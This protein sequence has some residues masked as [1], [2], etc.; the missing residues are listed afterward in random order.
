MTNPFNKTIIINKT[1]LRWCLRL[2]LFGIVAFTPS[3]AFAQSAIAPDNTLGAESSNVVTNVN[4]LPVEV[5]TGGATRGINLF[6]SFREFNVNEGRGAYFFSNSSNIQNIL[7]RVTGGNRSEIFGRLGTS[8]ESKANL[9]LINP[10]GIV[11]GQNASLDV[12]GS[13]MATTANGIQFGNQGSFNATNPQAPALL[14]VNPSALLFNQINTGVGITNQSQ[15]PTG[16]NPIGVNVTGLRVPDGKSLLL[17][18]GNINLDGGRLVA[19]EG[20]VELAG[21]ASP[22]SVGLNVI[23]NALSLNVPNDLQLADVSLSN[24]AFISAFGAGGGDITINARNIEMSNSQLYAGIGRNLGDVT[25]QAGDIKLNATGAISLKDSFLENSVYGRGNAGNIFI[26]APNTFS[27]TSSSVFSNVEAGGSGKAG[28]ININSGS[29]SI[30]DGAAIQTLLREGNDKYSPARGEGGNINID[31]GGAVNLFGEK[32]GFGSSIASTV[33]TNVEGNGGNI[34]IKSGSLS[35]ADGTSVNASTSGQGNAGNISVKARDAISL[36]GGDIFSIVGAGAVGNAGN[37]DIIGNSLS[38]TQN[39]QIATEVSQGNGNLP[40]GRGNGGNINIDV[41]GAVFIGNKKPGLTVNGISTLVRP[42]AEGNSGSITMNAGSLEV[43]NGSELQASN[44]G[45]GNTGNITINARDTVRFDGGDT[46]SNLVSRAINTVFEGNAGNINITTGSLSLSNLAF[47][48]SSTNGKGNAGNIT[49]NTRDVVNLDSLGY[50]SSDASFGSVGNGGEIKLTTGVL[51]LLNG[52]TISSSVYG[53]GNGGNIIIDARDSVLVDGINNK[54]V[55]NGTVYE[56]TSGLI[57]TL[58]TREVG[59]G[60]NIQITTGSL[61]VKNNGQLN[62]NTNGR[63]NAGNI[64]INARDTV[65]FDGL[66]KSPSIASSGA[67]DFFG[68]GE[69]L[70]SGGNI[71][72]NARALFLKNGG[73]ISANG[74]TGNAGNITIDVSDIVSIDGVD[75]SELGLLSSGITSQVKG[76]SIRLEESNTLVNGGDIRINTKELFLSNGGIIAADSVGFANAGNITINARDT[77]NFDGVGTNGASSG[78]T[79]QLLGGKG[80]GGDI[81]L[82]TGF[83]TLSN[84]AAINSNSN[85]QGNA[86]SIFINARDAIT[87]KDVGNNGATSFISSVIFTSGVGKGGDIQI[88]SRTLSLSDSAFLGSNTFGQGNA[89]NIEINLAGNMSVNKAALLSSTLGEGDAGNIAINLTGDLNLQNSSQINTATY[90]QGSAGDIFVDAKN[91]IFLANNSLITSNVGTGSV[92]KGGDIDVNTK[93]LTL[94][95]GSQLATAVFRQFGDIPGG[96]GKAGDIRINASDSVTLSGIGLLGNSTGLV[97]LTERGAFGDAGNI[98]V[99][100][101]KFQLADGANAIASTFNDSKG[102][103]IMIN[104]NTFAAVNGGQVITNTRGSGNAGNIR[105]NVKDNITI[106]GSDPNFAQRLTRVAEGI[107]NIGSTDTVNDVIGNEGA[108][109][110]IFANTTVG[111]TGQGGSIFIDPP[112]ITI[113]DGAIS[114]NSSGLGD[115]GNIV[116]EAG[117]FTLSN[118]SISAQTASSQGGNIKLT[119]QDYLLLRNG[120]QI[121]T[122]AGTATAGGDGGNITIN[123]PFIIAVPNQNNDITANAYSGKGGNIN[124]QSLGIFGIETRPKLSE[125]TND[126]TASS[127]LGLSGTVDVNSPDNSA[128]Q[129]SLTELPT[130]AIDTNALIANSCIA[131]ANQKQEN[132]FIITGGGALPNRPG[133]VSM[134][135]YSINTVRGITNENT[136]RP[137]KKGDAIVEPTGVYRLPDG[138][139]VIS[140]ECQ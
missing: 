66:V 103:D 111:S 58:L 34:N 123:S 35:L 10:N 137:W 96:R 116:V 20:R 9:F 104:A 76:S 78:I 60:G 97:T 61:T 67:L 134:S 89:G 16:V 45:R 71:F 73:L 102:G 85:G 115:A 65:T 135:N 83:L 129:N 30:A 21:L 82:T 99:T 4:G 106:A 105:L 124:I 44:F 110:G 11:F 139:L 15:A 54:V 87:L 47:L 51:S 90:G 25:A 127:E 118:A 37:I 100:T 19:N 107:K 52:S 27:L 14:T 62:T 56:S 12:Q 79:S 63:G 64:I 108:A 57:S 1:L 46:T 128:I 138:Q 6:H 40:T 39:A 28:N 41:S 80:K 29:F 42:G 86:G 5:I 94:E 22:G 136:S 17:V 8:G 69:G 81:Q 48:S 125:R 55:F 92:G 88:N 23:D 75:G 74:S 114:V 117:K 72:I 50:V 31:V 121:S 24:Q 122:T 93:T 130:N 131:R 7:A 32:N 43:T 91:S 101:G 77:M 38:L 59:Q 18:G 2:S 140:R 49:I 126:I 133:E 3:S 68:I 53:Q 70:G 98:L 120:S 84:G 95:D 109:S 132:S 113:R 33:G 26:Q 36:T 119:T 13:F 112:N